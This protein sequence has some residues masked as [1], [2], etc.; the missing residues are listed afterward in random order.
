VS[1]TITSGFDTYKWMNGTL[2]LQT[3]TT[4]AYV[5]LFIRA[6]GAP[7]TISDDVTADPGAYVLRISNG[8]QTG[9][10]VDSAEIRLNGVVILGPSQ[11]KPTRQTISVPVTL[12]ASN[13]L[14][15]ELRSAPKSQLTITLSRSTATTP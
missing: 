4:T 8:D 11:F 13:T 12:A 2:V 1:G 9:H 5:G 7:K 6:T 15:V 3:Q 14:T 10:L